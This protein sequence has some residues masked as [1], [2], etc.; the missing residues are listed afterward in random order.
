M[1]NELQDMAPGSSWMATGRAGKF[2]CGG[3]QTSTYRDVL[4][5]KFLAP[6]SSL[7]RLQR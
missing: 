7:R 6:V 5:S 1:E 2:V 4:G 3:E